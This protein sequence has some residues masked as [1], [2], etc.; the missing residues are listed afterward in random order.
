MGGG[1][2]QTSEWNE[3]EVIFRWCRSKHNHRKKKKERKKKREAFGVCCI[4]KHMR[5]RCL[6]ISVHA[7]RFFF[8]FPHA[9]EGE[10]LCGDKL[11]TWVHEGKTYTVVI[12]NIHK[13]ACRKETTFSLS[14]FI[15]LI[16]PSLPPWLQPRVVSR[17]TGTTEGGVR[18]LCMN[19]CACTS[20]WVYVLH[21]NAKHYK[22]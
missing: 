14:Y 15:I 12:H 18:E 20:V 4:P 9:K 11:E 17:T 13:M 3:A 1:R 19:E 21:I 16:F 22:C 10:L 6:N 5:A 2:W 8:F 7:G